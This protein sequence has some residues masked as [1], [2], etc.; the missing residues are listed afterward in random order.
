[1]IGSSHAAVANYLDDVAR[2]LSDLDP[3]ERAEVLAGLREHLDAVI[4]PDAATDDDIHR[5]LTDLGPPDAIAREAL[6]S[7]QTSTAPRA[8]ITAAPQP[9]VPL[10]QRPWLP[11]LVVV[12]LTVAL[13][14]SMLVLFAGAAF[15]SVTTSSA[16]IDF[17][18]PTPTPSPGGDGFHAPEVEDFTPLEDERAS[19]WSRFAGATLGAVLFSL[20]LWGAAAVLLLASPLFTAAVRALGTLLVPISVSAVVAGAGLT[21]LLGGSG[22][23]P[24]SLLITG[25]AVVALTV[26]TVRAILRTGHPRV[27]SS[28]QA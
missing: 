6:A 25:P 12:L 10:S 18:T 28:R 13:G 15:I 8:T 19:M 1:M 3:A 5:V 23:P 20:P 11:S 24:W 21:Q 27:V 26:L 16:P 4:D 7:T 22:A 17:A 9:R 14:L 2:M